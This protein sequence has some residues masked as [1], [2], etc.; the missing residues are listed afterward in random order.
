MTDSEAFLQRLTVL[1][2]KEHVIRKIDSTTPGLPP[3]CCFIYHD[4]PE[5]GMTTAVTYG[6]SIAD[7][8]D[9]RYGKPELIVTVRSADESWALAAAFFAERF[10]GD[11]SFT[12]GSVFTLTEPICPESE[13]CGFVVFAPAILDERAMKL[14]LVT[15]TVNLVG[16]Y[17]IYSGEAELIRQIG[18][19]TF[20]RLPDLNLLDVKRADISRGD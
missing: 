6:L 3:V 10:R 14:T 1:F 17:P 19:E 11:K 8:P 4:L 5:P 7:H 20:W 13:M 18:L 12:Y 15:K 2:G 16:M 9:W